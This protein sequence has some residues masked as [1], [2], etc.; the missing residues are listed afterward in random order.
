MIKLMANFV[1]HLIVIF[2]LGV[3]GCALLLAWASSRPEPPMKSRPPLRVDDT[4]WVQRSCY[5][6][7]EKDANSMPIGYLDPPATVVLEDDEGQWVKL[8]DAPIKDFDSRRYI[9][10]GKLDFKTSYYIQRRFLTNTLPAYWEHGPIML[11]LQRPKAADNPRRRTEKRPKVERDVDEPNEGPQLN[12]RIKA[13]TPEPDN[14]SDKP[15]VA[16]NSIKSEREA[17]P[18]KVDPKH[19]EYAETALRAIKRHFIGKKDDLAIEKLLQIIKKYPN[20]E[21]AG[22]ARELLKN[23]QQ[24]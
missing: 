4:V 21:A 14:A 15:A 6:Y 5:V 23:L 9:A 13:V 18:V 24:D 22:E 7:P 12:D 10:Y 3:G 20:T 16:T 11:D 8:I 1:K 17:E 2:M 19:E